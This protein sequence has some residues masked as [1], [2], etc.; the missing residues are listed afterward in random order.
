[1]PVVLEDAFLQA[2]RDSLPELPQAKATRFAAAYELKPTDIELLTT[3]MDTADYFEVVAT[4]MGDPKLAANWVTGELSAVLNRDNLDISASRVEATALAGLLKRIQDNTISGK[5]AKEVFAAMWKSGDTAD[6]IIEA[7]GLKQITDSGAI[8]AI[9][10]QVIADNPEQVQQFRDGKEKVLGYLVGQV[11][12]ASKGKA[13][14]GQAN[15]VLR[16]KLSS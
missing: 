6:A 9:V 4:D 8:E 1:L 5:I 10:E 14:P 11:M 12:Q 13:N 2:A 7:Q 15:Q 16:A 3:S